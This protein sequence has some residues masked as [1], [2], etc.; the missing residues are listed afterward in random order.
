LIC[1][2]PS[3][4]DDFSSNNSYHITLPFVGTKK[5][6]YKKRIGSK[7]V[8]RL[9]TTFFSFFWLFNR[10]D[11]INGKKFYNFSAEKVFS[12]RY[13]LNFFLLQ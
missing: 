10:K 1:G 13:K 2:L 7:T 5:D 6:R 11:E 12:L 8:F 9:L 4:G 3:I